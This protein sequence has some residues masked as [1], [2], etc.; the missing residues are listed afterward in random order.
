MEHDTVYDTDKLENITNKKLTDV[1]SET[2]KY[3]EV[4]DETIDF[5]PAEEVDTE[6][7]DI[8]KITELQLDN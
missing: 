2:K 5:Y 3:D 4:L 1:I 6:M 8:N 7:E